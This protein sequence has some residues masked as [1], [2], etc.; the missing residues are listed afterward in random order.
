[1]VCALCS[2]LYR[3]GCWGVEFINPFQGHRVGGCGAEMLLSRLCSRSLSA[4]ATG[5]EK[6]PQS[7]IPTRN[8]Q[9]RK[10]TWDAGRR[11]TTG[12]YPGLQVRWDPVFSS[13]PRRGSN[14]WPSP[15]FCRWGPKRVLVTSEPSYG[16][17]SCTLTIWPMWYQYCLIGVF[18][19]DKGA[20]IC[21]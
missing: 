19:N 4:P 3:R 15:G 17:I 21:H 6:P 20:W 5:S 13:S 2:P 9:H 8:P 7:V 18:F 14:D 1:M 16:N 12:L 10:W 11:E